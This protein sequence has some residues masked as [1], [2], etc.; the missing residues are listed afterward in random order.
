MNEHI[1]KMLP[2]FMSSY[3]IMPFM[4]YD[5]SQWSSSIT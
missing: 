5:I 4:S 1:L 2:K 3:I